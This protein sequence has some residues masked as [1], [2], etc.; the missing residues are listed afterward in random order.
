MD[1]RHAVIGGEVLGLLGRRDLLALAAL[2]RGAAGLELDA[3]VVRA[4][5]N[6][7]KAAGDQVKKGKDVIMVLKPRTGTLP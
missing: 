1:L 2:C 7:K 3:A 6:V 5:V 4:A